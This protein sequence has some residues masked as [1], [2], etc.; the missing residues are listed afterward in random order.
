MS[1]LEPPRDKRAAI[2][3]CWGFAVI[4][5]LVLRSINMTLWGV[6]L[7]FRK[8][9]AWSG[10]PVIIHY[11]PVVSPELFTSSSGSAHGLPDDFEQG[12]LLQMPDILNVF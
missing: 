6:H 11:L 10:W 2:C 3:T 9:E 4:S 1:N 7:D 12:T 8:P 5:A